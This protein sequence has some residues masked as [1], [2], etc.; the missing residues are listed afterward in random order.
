M[1]T[2][3]N[4]IFCS[5]PVDTT[6]TGFENDSESSIFK[7]KIQQT[8]E[9][10]LESSLRELEIHDDVWIPVKRSH[11]MQVYFPVDQEDNEAV[12]QYLGSK[13]FGAHGTSLGFIPFALFF[14]ESEEDYDDLDDE[15]F[16]TITVD[17][18]KIPEGNSRRFI[19]KLTNKLSSF[20]K[21]QEDFLKSVTSRLTVA[22]VVSGVKNSSK[23]TFDFVMYTFFA[24][25]IASCG[26]MNSSVIDIAAAMCIEPVMAT[27]LVG[28]F[29]TVIHDW[30]L[31]KTGIRN[32][33]IVTVECIFVGYVYGLIVMIWS[34]EWGPP[35]G[36]WP[37][38]EMVGRAEWRSLVM[39]A[40][41]ASA[42]GGAV[43]L[44]LLS[45]NYTA[46]VG[47]AIASTFLPHAVNT[48]L[49]WAWICHLSWRGAKEQ[50]IFINVT[51]PA[52]VVKE[53]YTK[54]TFLPMEG[55]TPIYSWDMRM[56]CLQLSYVSLLNCY[57]NV[58]CLYIF[59]TLVLKL[60]EVAPLGSFE[61]HRKFFQE[62][63]KAYRD[64]NY[65]RR[66][67]KAP[68]TSKVGRRA[69]D[70][71]GAQILRE[72]ADI[73]GL[74]AETL[75]STS[76]EAKVTQIQTLTDLATEIEAD[77][78]YQTITRSAIGQI[79]ELS[80][81]RR[82]TRGSISFSPFSS[83]G[84]DNP[85]Y[86]RS[87]EHLNSVQKT[88]NHPPIMRKISRVKPV[89]RRASCIVSSVDESPP[90][91]GMT[92]EELEDGTR[93]SILL[94]KSLEESEHS[95]YSLWPS[96]RRPS[97]TAIPNVI[98][99]HSASPSISRSISLADARKRKSNSSTAS[100]TRI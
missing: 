65:T 59:C 31:I 49:L 68:D 6:Y 61:P 81:V 53:V 89:N 10:V 51:T 35:E 60:K 64:Y 15:V 11:R 67:S 74:N 23:V 8:W 66:A 30:S 45:N 43:A 46:F 39:G 33:L 44:S 25:C 22:Q 48:G 80:L 20:K 21:V 9:E 94:R 92:P 38:S 86:A 58:L 13:G 12:L 90:V 87:T 97:S 36:R 73:A 50:H 76:P 41:Q 27:V 17:D 57:V 55:Y 7:V 42:A 88:V 69:S 56:E 72:W 54:P 83:L 3:T 96:G 18:E 2:E 19:K 99:H 28:A 32:N 100:N 40:L 82:L 98:V 47:V 77:Q 29:G 75:L 14:R 37:T 93:P 63:I 4:W 62:D 95:P 85:A 71:L 52:G 34:I 79:P 1:P 84:V 91:R 16:E 26:I 24:G 78:N 5:I 70:D